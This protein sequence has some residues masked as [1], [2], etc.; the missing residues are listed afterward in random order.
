LC[1][2]NYYFFGEGHP[3]VLYNWKT[4]INLFVSV[5]HKN[6]LLLNLLAT[7]FNHYTIISL[8]VHKF[9]N[10]LHVVHI[11]VSVMWDPI[12]LTPVLKH[13]KNLSYI[14]YD[15]IRDVLISE[16]KL[17]L[18]LMHSNITLSLDCVKIIYIYLCVCVCVVF[19]H[20]LWYM[21]LG[22]V[23]VFL[24]RICQILGGACRL[25][26][27]LLCVCLWWQISVVS[28]V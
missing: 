18:K 13:V 26:L 27:Y 12:K 4:I 6:I 23:F 8:S 20:K 16:M 3:I 2:R 10:R 14:A 7:S 15:I 1:W 22:T 24:Y 21:L 28:S 17:K 19:S 11:K 5:K 9:Y 25:Y